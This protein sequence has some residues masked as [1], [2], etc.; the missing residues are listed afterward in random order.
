MEFQ[1][2]KRIWIKSIYYQNLDKKDMSLSSQ[3]QRMKSRG[4]KSTMNPSGYMKLRNHV[5]SQN[6]AEKVVSIN[7]IQ[8]LIKKVTKKSG[9]LQNLGFPEL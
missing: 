5:I 9:H 7:S 8:N 4:R 3:N 1:K 6:K 2:L